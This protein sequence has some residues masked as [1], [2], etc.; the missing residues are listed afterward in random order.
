MA[1]PAS[2]GTFTSSLRQRLI[3]FLRSIGGT[4]IV[5]PVGLAASAAAFH[6][7]GQSAER[8]TA[9][10]LDAAVREAAHSVELEMRA[11]AQVLHAM[12][13]LFSADTGITREQ[14]HRFVATLDLPARYP[15]FQSVG[16]ARFVTAAERDAYERAIS[17][18]HGLPRFQ[19]LDTLGRPAPR[20]LPWHF[21]VEYAYPDALPQSATF[22]FD[23]SADPQRRHASIHQ[24]ESGDMTSSGI[25]ITRTS[26][27]LN[28]NVLPMRIPVYRTGIPLTNADARWNAVIGSVGTY[29]QVRHMFD[30]ALKESKLHLRV[31]DVG[32]SSKPFDPTTKAA[33]LLYDN[34]QPDRFM[35]ERGPIARDARLQ[36]TVLTEW[37]TRRWALQF[38]SDSPLISRMDESMPWLFALGGTTTT[39]LV[40]AWLQ[41][42]ARSR[43]HALAA[44]RAQTQF[45]TNMSH[46]LRTPLNAILGC[47]QLLT[48]AGD[49]RLDARQAS[50]VRTIH[51]SGEHLLSLIDDMLDLARVEAGKLELNASTVNLPGLIDEVVG[52]IGVKA[53]QKGL[54]FEIENSG[55]PPLVRVDGQR[56]RQVLLNLLGNAVKFTDQGHVRLGVRYAAGPAGEGSPGLLRFV[57]QDSGIGMDEHQIG[58]LFQPFQQVGD[59][60]RRLGGTG[61]GLAISRQ[62]VSMMGGDIRVDSSPGAG[63]RFSFDIPVAVEA[64]QPLP[65][66]APRLP[67][68]HAGRQRRLLVVD[69]SAANRL[70]LSETL[71]L[72]GFQVVEASDG[73]Q[74]LA[75]ARSTSPD[76]ILMDG[77]LPGLSG[78]EATRQLR[79]MPGFGTVPI[80][81]ISASAT[82]EDN[83]KALAAGAD[84][85]LPKPFR[86][87]ALIAALERHLQLEFVYEQP[88]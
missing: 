2:P 44:R 82:P 16:F 23:I 76:L 88:G 53:D 66:P 31:Y 68:G 28:S 78:L 87:A 14:Y 57:V 81:A 84:A 12:Q 41:A 30:R 51:S 71:G 49:G 10:R 39:V 22:G 42:L 18:A 47:T 55:V 26:Q 29:F 9:L 4:W 1:A 27:R 50:G 61:L 54:R 80:I 15:A 38:S 58:Q 7:A 69:D 24:V 25:P 40:F 3:E 64:L 85:F 74:C 48:L 46:E 75:L 5:L 34:R 65:E 6:F 32:H 52:I 17:K 79:A 35:T 86:A 37:A 62:L 56:L 77:Q 20:D 72:M 67:S 63:S 70:V 8:E 73:A 59:R 33:M 13:A 60:R 45:L 83:A 11:Y 43:S 21:V 19:V 36:R